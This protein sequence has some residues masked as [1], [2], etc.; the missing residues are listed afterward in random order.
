MSATRSGKAAVFIFDRP[1]DMRHTGSSAGPNRHMQMFEWIRKFVAGLAGEATQP[2]GFGDSDYRLAAAALLIRVA[3]VDSAMSSHKRAVLH[4]VMKYRF[5][6][7]DASA[8]A[9]IDE[10]AEADRC[11]VDLYHF[12]SRIS[13]SLDAEGRRRI[14]EMMWEIIHAG[15]RTSEFADNIVWRAADLL[16][17]SSRERI[18]L[19]RSTATRAAIGHTL[20]KPAGA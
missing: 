2:H 13:R 7:D 10:A 19:R 20:A 17:V 1:K 11:A 3:T 4:A 14:V 8:A 16:G 6:L 12:T 15:G 5:G 9:L 18:A